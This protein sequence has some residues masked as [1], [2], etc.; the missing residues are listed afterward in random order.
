MCLFPYPDGFARVTQAFIVVR[1]KKG[2]TSSGGES[3]YYLAPKCL[4][5]GG[6]KQIQLRMLSPS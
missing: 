5:K 4:Y 2:P 6:Y 1:A 3:M